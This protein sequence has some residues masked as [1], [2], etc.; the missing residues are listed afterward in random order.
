[1]PTGI[2][3]LIS[4][5]NGSFAAIFAL[6]IAGVPASADQPVRLYL[7]NDDHTDTKWTV[8]TESYGRVFVEMLDYC[9]RP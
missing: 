6:A 8:D 3:P 5:T 1:M 7:A 9:L 2:R 4:M